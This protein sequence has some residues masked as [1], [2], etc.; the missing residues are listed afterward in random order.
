[1]KRELECLCVAF[2]SILCSV[3]GTFY[4]IR[5]I[6]ILYFEK[7]LVGKLYYPIKTQ[8]SVIVSIL[9]FLFLFLFVNPTLLYLFSYKF[10]LLLGFNV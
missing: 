2:V 7:T 6:K 8:S 3:I 10:S 9:F 4:Y 5:L 1:M